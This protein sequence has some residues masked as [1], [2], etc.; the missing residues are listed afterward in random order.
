M[1][2][3]SQQL[4]CFQ[5][6]DEGGNLLVEAVREGKTLKMLT[7]NGNAELSWEVRVQVRKALTRNYKDKTANSVELEDIDTN[8]ITPLED[9]SNAD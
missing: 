7:L 6:T 4:F 8:T 5:I 9:I 2:I 1:L 3:F